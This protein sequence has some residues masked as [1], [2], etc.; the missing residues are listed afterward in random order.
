M[1]I[2]TL[3]LGLLLAVSLS[4]AAFSQTGKGVDT[5]TRKIK[6]D[7]TKA[8]SRP[9]DASRSWDW[10]KGKTKV[11]D[12]LPNPFKFAGR[13]D[14]LIELVM[15]ALQEKKILLD[16][17]A[18]RVKDGVIITQPF[19]FA[20]GPVTSR[21]ELVRYG[22]VEYADSAWSRGQYTL[23]IEVQ[24]IDAT[25]NNVSVVAKVVG[26]SGNGIGSEWR[27]VSSSGLA[28]DEFLATLV[29]L[30][31]GKSPDDQPQQ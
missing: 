18:S 28:E 2:K 23:T 13:R 17:A 15:Q 12:P 8:V 29:E 14:A 7:S 19:V 4:A 3:I 30:V 10:G 25:Q 1:T 20:K 9:T 11:R 5:Q 21:G 22:V 27:S 6:D 26:L 31:T 16:E 24:P